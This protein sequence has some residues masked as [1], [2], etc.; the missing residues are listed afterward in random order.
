MELIV[1]LAI[2]AVLVTLLAPSISQVPTR[3]T[4]PI[5]HF[6]EQERSQAIKD[7]KAAP[8][9]YADRAL[10]SQATHARFEL[11]KGERLEIQDPRSGDYLPATELTTFYPDGSMAATEFLHITPDNTHAIE[12]SPFNGKISFRTER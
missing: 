4:P 3:T 7:G 5:I 6:L 2:I 9:L 10:V 8:I 1:V 11:S 12:I